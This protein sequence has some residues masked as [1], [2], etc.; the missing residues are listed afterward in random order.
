[1]GRIGENLQGHDL[2]EEKDDPADLEE[3]VTDFLSRHDIAADVGAALR[4]LPLERQREVVAADLTGAN[5]P[6]AVLLSRIKRATK[7][8]K[9][10][11]RRENV[12][13]F[14]RNNTFDEDACRSF[15]DL[16]PELQG[17]IMSEDF[18]RC[19][20]PSA[21]LMA[22]IRALKDSSSGPIGALPGPSSGQASDVVETFLFQHGIDEG[23][24]EALRQLPAPLQLQVLA[25]DFEIGQG[26]RNPS[27]HLV[28]LV[29]MAWAGS[30]KPP[31]A[32]D[33]HEEFLDRH[34][35]DVRARQAFYE[36]TMPLRQAVVNEGPIINCHNPSAVLFSRIAR[37]R[38]TSLDAMPPHALQM[39]AYGLPPHMPPHVPHVPH[40]PPHVAPHGTPLMPPHGLPHVPPHV[41]HSISPW[42][43]PP[44]DFSHIQPGPPP[45][46]EPPGPA[47]APALAAPGGAEAKRRRVEREPPESR[48]QEPSL[49]VEGF[50]RLNGI[51][52]KSC[53]A[54]RRLPPAAQEKLIGMDLRQR[55]NPSAFLWAQIQK[56]DLDRGPPPEKPAVKQEKGELLF[57]LARH[58]QTSSVPPL[59]EITAGTSCLTC[60]RSTQNDIVFKAQHA[61][62]RHAEFHIEHASGEPLLLLRDF[63]SNGTWV[64]GAKLQPGR[65]TRLVSGDIVSFLPPAEDAPAFQVLDATISGKHFQPQPEP[66]ARAVPALADVPEAAGEVGEWIRSIGGGG[67]LSARLIEEIEDSYDHLRQIYDNYRRNISDF[68]D[69]HSVDDPD[70]QEILSEAI[71]TL[72]SWQRAE[73][74]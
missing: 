67:K 52:A 9:P 46:G 10:R 66:V 17:Q 61:S 56:L 12:A 22:R 26:G 31:Q 28:S 62:K 19:R 3:Q 4:K 40:V 51:D 55:R 32:M 71:A 24:R 1:M 63:S 64:N 5:K 39:P 16:G 21:F 38:N 7:D 14:L 54:M 48:E 72:C 6:S 15:R 69:V 68:L 36:L 65:P 18:S 33:P 60:G 45:P 34:Q 8:R 29:G 42:P 41:L 49:A 73:N 37:F 44:P 11:Q 25:H 57:F 70:E 59:V 27:Q 74:D 20:N 35:V 23:G 13:A 30:L 2:P 58:G 47:P 43:L 50:L 53:R